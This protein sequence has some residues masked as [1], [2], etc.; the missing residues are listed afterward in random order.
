MMYARQMTI[1]G[2][3]QSEPATIQMKRYVSGFRLNTLCTQD[4]SKATAMAISR[5]TVFQPQSDSVHFQISLIQPGNVNVT[6]NPTLTPQLMMSIAIC[7]CV[8]FTPSTAS[9]DEV[10][11]VGGDVVVVKHLT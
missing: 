8:T 9:D 3:A 10:R 1:I 2:I 4:G 6:T 5:A 11:N 7:P